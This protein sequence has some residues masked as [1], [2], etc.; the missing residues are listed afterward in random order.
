MIETRASSPVFV[1]GASG[2]GKVVADILLTQRIS[3]AGFIDDAAPTNSADILG[4]KVL[5]DGN[6]FFQEAERR[7]RRAVAAL[8]IGDNAAR[9]RIAERCVEAG[10]ELLTAVHS[11]A[12]VALSAHLSPGVVVMAAAVVN[13]DAH[14]GTGAIINTAAIVDHDCRVGDF[15]H[16]APNATM[17]GGARLGGLSWLGMGANI[18]HGVTVGSGTIIGAGAVVV[19]DIPDQVVAMGI[20]ACVRRR[21]SE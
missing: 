20:P 6:W 19:R 5:G 13:P 7:N 4:L 8:G 10:V 21:R 14:I 11:S 12:V 16:V 15:A 1:Y 2:H 9:R 18:I 3:V 17:G